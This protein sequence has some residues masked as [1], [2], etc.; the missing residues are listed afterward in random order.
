MQWVANEY[1]ASIVENRK[2][3]VRKARLAGAEAL[4]FFVEGLC[5]STAVVFLL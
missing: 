5:L 4:C 1:E 3:L 2:V